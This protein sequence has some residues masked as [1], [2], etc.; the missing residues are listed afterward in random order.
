M[1]FFYF[2]TQPSRITKPPKTPSRIDDDRKNTDSDSDM[3]GQ[4]QGRQGRSKSLSR[5]G[6]ADPDSRQ[7]ES[8]GQSRVRSSL[9]PLTVANGVSHFECALS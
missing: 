1:L 6:T 5:L 3:E 7:T 4:G 8:R 9:R 2:L